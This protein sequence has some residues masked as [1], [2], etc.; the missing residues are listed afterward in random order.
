MNCFS[1]DPN[2][3]WLFVFAHPDDEIA[4]AGW[5]HHLVSFGVPVTCAW[6]HQTRVRRKESE[7]A[8]W[9]LGV[10]PEDQHFGDFPDG[11]FVDHLDQLTEWAESLINGVE[12]TRVVTGAFEQGHLDHDSL[13]FSIK[14]AWQGTYLEF[15][16]YHAFCNVIQKI[17]A[18]S[19]PN[20]GQ[21]WEIPPSGQIAKVSLIDCY[22]SQTVARNLKL[23]RQLTKFTG[24]PADIDHIEKLRLH[25]VVDFLSPNAPPELAKRILKTKEWKRWMRA[26]EGRIR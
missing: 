5:I 24:D 1:I 13:N 8:M 20:S 10:L 26:M 9:I 25:T 3:H 19:D 17:N 16:L 12:P 23:Y 11:N 7:D 15:P 2:D 18:F 6:A 14:K 4:I 22:P 21:N